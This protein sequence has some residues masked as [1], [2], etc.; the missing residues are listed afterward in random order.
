[1]KVSQPF[2]D[3]P[4]IWRVTLEPGEAG[5]VISRLSAA[6]R[7]DGRPGPNIAWSGYGPE[8][9]DDHRLQFVIEEREEVVGE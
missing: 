7:G 5:A 4:H 2:E 6:L 9:A 8:T 1:M 3:H